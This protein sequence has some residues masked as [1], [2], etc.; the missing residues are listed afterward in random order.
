MRKSFYLLL[1]A[2]S[3]LS[4]LSVFAQEFGVKFS[5]YVKTDFFYDTRQTVSLREGD[6][7]LYP[8][9]RN[10][11]SEG[12]DINDN[13][14]FNFISIQTRLTG[15]ITA[16]DA[17]GAKISGVVEA[18]FFGN[19]NAAFVDA[20]G[21]RL[22]HAFAKLSWEKTELLLGQFWHPFFIQDCFSEVISFNTGAPM[23]PFARNPQIRI[24]HKLGDFSILG[25]AT[26]QRD[27]TSPGGS[28]VLRNAFIP[29]MNAQLQ[30]RKVYPDSKSEIYTGIGAEF[31]S[32][33]PLLQ[34]EKSGKKYSTDERV[35]SYALTA[36]FKYKNPS[37]TYKVQGIYGQNLF[38]LT[39]LGGY[40]V[41]SV[42]DTNKNTVAYTT[43]NT[44][45]LWSEFILTSVKNLQF[46]LWAGYTEN[47]GSDDNILIYSNKVNGVD[48]T[49][50]AAAP[51]NSSDIKSVLRISPRIVWILER[52][53][54]AFETEYTAAQYALKDA[55]GKLY[56][57]SKGKI[58]ETETIS[59]I[60]FLFSA[61]LKF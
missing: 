10:Y 20:N 32:I 12:K 41:K 27:F 22:R 61:I 21:F 19:E 54:F 31:K 49:V 37:F 44:L 52:L 35:N 43:P 14:S 55:S 50:R 60:R 33:K 13:P 28:N 6:F 8:A 24:V 18:D 46:G 42:I 34:S 25:A 5:G 1:I 38:D 7:L 56:R 58:T 4:Q 2:F 29:D 17:L 30:F 47:F 23:Q 16:P 3:F 11:D 9:G 15:N 26:A 39:M 36:F 53:N 48:M 45:S 57:D 40:A 59:N 51:D